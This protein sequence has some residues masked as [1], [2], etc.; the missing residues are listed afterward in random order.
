ML[1][2][3][4]NLIKTQPYFNKTKNF[5]SKIELVCVGF[6][7]R[8]T[9]QNEKWYEKR[10]Q[11]SSWDIF[12]RKKLQNISFSEV[13]LFIIE[14]TDKIEFKKCVSMKCWIFQQYRT[15]ATVHVQHLLLLLL[16]LRQLQ[17]TYLP[18]QLKKSLLIMRLIY[19]LSVCIL[20]WKVK[21]WMIYHIVVII[22]T[23]NVLVYYI[24]KC[25]LIFISSE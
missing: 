13:H 23:Q 2:R 4:K 18:G 16:Y 19:L 22:F 3:V 24:V 17:E 1:K 15:S 11:L 12:R 9:F 5:I 6:F 25:V 7:S 14:E 20:M 10:Y 21:N 8:S